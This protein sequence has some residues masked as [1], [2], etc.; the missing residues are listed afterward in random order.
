MSVDTMDIERIDSLQK[1]ELADGVDVKVYTAGAFPRVL[2]ALLDLV[3]MGLLFAASVLVISLVVGL[4]GVYLNIGGINQILMGF[5]M[6]YL[7][8]FMWF[9]NFFFERGKKAATWGK[10][11]VG[12]K[13]VSTDGSRADEKQI[14]IRNILRAADLLP[15]APLYMWFPN[16]FLQMGLMMLGIGIFTM[17]TYG[18]GLTACLLTPRFQR[19]GDLVAGTIVVHTTEMRYF[20]K[21]TITVKEKKI[22]R[23]KIL[24]EEEV[25]IREFSERAVMWSPARRNEIASH[26]AELTDKDGDEA[27]RELLAYSNWIEE[28]K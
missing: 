26:A 21:N 28:K 3:F 14:F 17:G 5:I 22:P 1:V 20:S 25:A 18:V 15:G 2:A 7:F 19:I 23:L 8:I 6:I 10:R 4:L 13:V 9:Y 27:V 16:E 11:I 12:L 24:R